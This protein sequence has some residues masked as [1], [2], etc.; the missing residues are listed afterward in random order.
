[1]KKG[2][3]LIELLAVIVILAIIALIA[4]PII[5]N[6]IN[7]SKESTI[8]RSSEQYISALELTLLKVEMDNNDITTCIVEDKN[9]KCGE[10]EYKIELDGEYPEEP[11][12]EI[13]STGKMDIA[14]KTNGYC[15]LKRKEEDNYLFKKIVDKVK[16]SKNEITNNNCSL[17]PYTSEKCFAFDSS[18]GTI[19]KYYSNENN[20]KTNPACPKE[21]VV[22]KKINGVKLTT[23]ANSA[24]YSYGLT[25]V[26]FPN[27]LTTIGSAAF[28][29]NRLT[30]LVIPEGVKSIGIESF[31]DNSIMSLNL[32]ST[33]ITVGNHAFRNNKLSQESAYLYKRNSDGSI[34]YT[35]II[36]YGG[37]DK[38]IIIPSEKNGIK[39]KTIA[40]SAFYSNKLTNIEIPNTVTTISA[41]AFRNN[42]LTNL[43]IPEGVKT[44]G[45][46]AFDTNLIS[47]LSLPSTL[48]TIS[49]AAFNNNKLPQE[50]A[51]IYKRNSDGSIDYTTLVSYG[52]LDKDI[53]IPSEK[54]GLKLTKIGSSAFYNNGLTSVTI[55]DSVMMIGWGAF[56]NNKLTSIIIPKSVKNIE[57]N[58]FSNNK[59]TSVIIKNTSDKVKLSSNSFGTFD[60]KNIKWEPNE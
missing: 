53:E 25:K 35:T 12:I 22:P 2:F 6:T 14:L 24:F 43:N 5:L 31:A 48:T 30:K 28:R 55:P 59:I 10:K 9:L 40:N 34:D 36:G 47:T 11:E 18:T 44:I 50:S 60:N 15:I 4:T 58:A 42:Y 32:P 46:E 38:N 54:N 26:E 41:F 49:S 29:N 19:T 1:M 7:N 57:Y 51:Y 39:L 21:V 56:N 37:L 13:Y 23:I 27:T 33:L 16:D 20:D 52:G 45:E 8:K 17:Y 3:T